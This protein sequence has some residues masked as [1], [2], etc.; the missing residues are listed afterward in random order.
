MREQ[1]KRVIKQ[2]FELTEVDD[3]ISQH[4]CAKWDSLK[5]LNLMLDLETEFKVSLEPEEIAEMKSLDSI[6]HI[7]RNLTD[8]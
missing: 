6:E 3:D 1:I 2:C 5:H 8:E 7:L 4:N